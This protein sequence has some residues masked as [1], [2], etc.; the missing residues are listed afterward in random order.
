M[1]NAERGVVGEW[2]QGP[3]S[4]NPHDSSA[5]LVSITITD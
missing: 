5:I 3:K 4:A 2:L 1:Y